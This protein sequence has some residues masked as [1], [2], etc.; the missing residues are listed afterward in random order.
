GFTATFIA[1]RRVPKDLGQALLGLGLMFLGL[2]LI[3]DNAGA[4]KASPLALDLLAAVA[5]SPAIGV[6]VGALFSALVTSSAATLGL[7]LAFAQQGLL[8]LDGAVGVVVGANIGTWAAAVAASVD[9]LD[10]DKSVAVDTHAVKVVGGG[11]DF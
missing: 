9:A 10:E 6:L 4:L 3:L 1:R 2:K 11:L 8:P 7:A 5:Q